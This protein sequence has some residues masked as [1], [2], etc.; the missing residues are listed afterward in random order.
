MHESGFPGFEASG[1]NALFA[2]AGTPR[3]IIDKVST[4]RERLTSR[5]MRARAQLR[6]LGITPLGGS[7]EELKAHLN[8]ETAKWG[9]IIKEP[10]SRWNRRHAL[11]PE[12]RKEDGHARS[13][14]ET[15]CDA[16]LHAFGDAKTYPVGNP[17]ALYR[18]P[19][20][21]TFEA[22]KAL[23]APPPRGVR[24]AHHLRHRSTLAARRAQGRAERKIS[25]RRNRRR[26]RERRRARSSLPVSACAAHASTSVAISSLR[27]AFLFAICS[28]ASVKAFGFG[29]DFLAVEAEL[30]KIKSPAIIDHLGGPGRGAGYICLCHANAARPAEERKL[31]GEPFQWRPSLAARRA[32]GRHGGI[33]PDVRRGSAGPLPV[34]DPLA[35]RPCRA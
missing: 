24:A 35:A 28:T 2:P 6:K 7:P 5:A 31:V 27:R 18:P 30:R 10:T 34:G 29:D 16:H 33:R 4:R 9:P 11:P 12:A 26:Q 32:M 14:A 25:R 13:P 19:Q 17:N 8:R 3:E 1:W 22:M 15:S 21:C 20:D 23:H